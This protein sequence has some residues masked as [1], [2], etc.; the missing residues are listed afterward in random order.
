METHPAPVPSASR[1]VRA[2]LRSLLPR[3]VFL[4][5]LTT[6]LGFRSRL[7]AI[8]HILRGHRVT[9]YVGGALPWIGF[10]GSI[11]CEECPDCGGQGLGI[12]GRNS[13]LIGFFGRRL[14]R[15]L[16]HGKPE[17]HKQWTGGYDEA[18][19]MAWEP[20]PGLSCSRC[21]ANLPG[22]EEATP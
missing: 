20:A 12:W 7:D 3:P 9:W 22:A 6:W 4:A 11:V 2:C 14:C 13:S 19:E 5:L 16:G 15:R 17:Q 1:R 18:G 10:F 8:G 21:L